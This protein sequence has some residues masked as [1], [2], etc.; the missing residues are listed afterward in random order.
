MNQPNLT[1]Y[2]ADCL[3]EF[4]VDADDWTPADVMDRQEWQL[5][6]EAIEARLRARLSKPDLSLS[7]PEVSICYHK[8]VS[9]FIALIAQRASLLER[10][11][12]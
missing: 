6:Y 3:M 5:A 4:G 8:P 9:D 7:D 11:L 12:I 2:V 1:K 10:R